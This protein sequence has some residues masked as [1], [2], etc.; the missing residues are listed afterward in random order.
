MIFLQRGFRLSLERR[1]EDRILCSNVKA[2]AFQQPLSSPFHCTLFV[3]AHFSPLPH[4]PLVSS[5][6]ASAPLLSRSPPLCHLSVVF[7]SLT[8]PWFPRAARPPASPRPLARAELH[9]G[10]TR[11]SL[12]A[13][14]QVNMNMHVQFSHLHNGSSCIQ[15]R[16]VR[17]G[18]SISAAC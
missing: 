12:N 11:N 10:D 4:L 3:S 8:S 7:F 17:L 14:T 18:V 5:S 15:K 13:Q 16:T 9:P 1:A 6:P 2:S